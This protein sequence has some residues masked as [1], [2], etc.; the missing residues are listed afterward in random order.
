MPLALYPAGFWP[1]GEALLRLR[2][3]EEAR[4][5]DAGRLSSVW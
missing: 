4:P 5:G 3:E 2:R 1:P